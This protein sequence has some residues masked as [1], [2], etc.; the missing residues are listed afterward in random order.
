MAVDIFVST[1]SCISSIA[2]L[3]LGAHSVSGTLAQL[4][5]SCLVG[6]PPLTGVERQRVGQPEARRGAGAHTGHVPLLLFKLPSAL[7]FMSPASCCLAE[8]LPIASL[9]SCSFSLK[10]PVI[11]SSVP[12]CILQPP[13]FGSSLYTSQEVIMS[14]CTTMSCLAISPVLTCH[15]RNHSK[16]KYKCRQ[17][18]ALIL[19]KYFSNTPLFEVLA[20]KVAPFLANLTLFSLVAAEKQELKIFQQLFPHC[21]PGSKTPFTF[22]PRFLEGRCKKCF[23]I[24]GRLCVRHPPHSHVNSPVLQR[25]RAPLNFYWSK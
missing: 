21:K 3:T 4:R 12:H 25:S 2:C 8:P 15:V 6:Q 5:C 22:L 7:S 13:G 23:H 11:A 20:L 24:V 10:N 14:P 1:V 17:N 19:N 16:F 18:Q 9:N